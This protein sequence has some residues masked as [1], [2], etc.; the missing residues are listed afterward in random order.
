MEYIIATVLTTTKK[1]RLFSFH[2]IVIKS[3][4]EQNEIAVSNR[5]NFGR[6][7]R[8]CEYTVHRP[9]M[10]HMYLY[11]HL[12]NVLQDY[13]SRMRQALYTILSEYCSL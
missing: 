3:R 1:E 8:K 13:A 7:A 2:V 11:L 10:P 5:I 4:K 9:S 12:N 6:T